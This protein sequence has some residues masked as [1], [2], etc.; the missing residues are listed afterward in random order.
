MH[1]RPQSRP[2][3]QITQISLPSVSSLLFPLQ[4]CGLVD[5]DNV[6]IDTRDVSSQCQDSFLKYRLGDRQEMVVIGL[7]DQK[8][9]AEGSF[10]WSFDGALNL[11]IGKIRAL[12][13]IYDEE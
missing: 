13:R 12:N 5:L 4:S 10:Q 11:D 7:C 9:Q 6:N 3:T 8:I 2:A 1:Y